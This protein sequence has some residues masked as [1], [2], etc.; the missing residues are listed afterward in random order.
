[1]TDLEGARKRWLADREQWEKF[2][3]EAA[4][5]LKTA[6]RRRGIWAQVSTRVK[7]MDS[8]IKKLMNKPDKTY[9]S[10]GDKVGVRIVVRYVSEIE[11]VM[12]LVGELFACS[13]RENKLS[14][15]GPD[16]VG[17][18]STHVDIRL[19]NGDPLAAK[20]SPSVYHAELQVRT[21][22]QHLWADMAHD[23]FYKND[24]TLNPLP[25]P[26]KRRVNVLAGVVEVADNEFD[27]L[28][29]KTPGKPEVVML[30][31]LEKHYWTLTSRRYNVELSLKVIRLLSPL[32][33]SKP[34]QIVV[35]FREFF[36]EHAEVLTTVYSEAA[37]DMARSAFLYQPEALMIYD[38]LDSKQIQTHHLWNTE[39]P[40][41][42]LERIATAFGISLH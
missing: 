35:H 17:Y 4:E 40:E 15:L 24:E 6:L 33:K 8:L 41:R 34:R 7:E 31:S 29:R 28:N 11:G 13:G 14:K 30:K 2:G 39:F 20:F 23:T 1:M 9:E 22:A 25:L 42:E 3:Q 10:L 19:K 16:K 36:D 18:L 32:Y 26:L 38:L 21:M 27:R 37:D 5:K 12:T